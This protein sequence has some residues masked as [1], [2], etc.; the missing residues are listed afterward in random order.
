MIES[1]NWSE[2]SAFLRDVLEG[3]AQRAGGAH[4][5][6]RVNW[7]G[8]VA[9]IGAVTEAIDRLG[10]MSEMGDRLVQIR[11]LPASD[12][13]EAQACR[14]A[15]GRGD[16][17]EARRRLAETVCQFFDAIDSPDALLPMSDD[18]QARLITLVMLAA[19][20]R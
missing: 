6:K 17:A 8:R 12:D 11:L 18:D 4:G 7:K 3:D 2:V 9:I 20:C 13:D 10:G 16:Q 15:D 1:H 19:R 14:K 5:G